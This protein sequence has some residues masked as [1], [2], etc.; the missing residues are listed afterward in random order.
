MSLNSKQLGAVFAVLV[1]ALVGAFVVKDAG[2]TPMFA[3]M[4]VG[5]V[6]AGIVAFGGGGGIAI[7]GLSDAIRRAAAGDRV[8]SPP[9][10]TGELAR[11]CM[12]SW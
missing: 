7:V 3:V 2:T 1:L 6:S 5:V 9:D 12:K 11:V 4:A 8:K 10:A